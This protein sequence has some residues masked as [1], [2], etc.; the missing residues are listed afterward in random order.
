[1]H[2]LEITDAKFTWG[3]GD[4]K[5]YSNNI[6]LMVNLE[7]TFQTDTLNQVIL[8]ISDM[9]NLYENSPIT[10]HYNAIDITKL[11]CTTNDN[12]HTCNL[13]NLILK[14]T[15]P[16]TE[17]KARVNQQITTKNITLQET[18][19]NPNATFI[20]TNNCYENKCY[21]KS[22]QNF[23]TIKLANSDAGFSRGR[24][25]V[26]VG[27]IRTSVTSCN[28]NECLASIN[29]QCQDG[30][31]IQ[32][33]IDNYAPGIIS[34]DDA[35]RPITSENFQ[36]I[37]DSNPPEIR[38]IWTIQARELGVTDI[39]ETFRV[40]ANITD[41]VSPKIE[42]NIIGTNIGSNNVTGECVL[43]EGL[44]RCSGSIKAQ[45]PER[46]LY[47]VPVIFKDVAGNEIQE[48]MQVELVEVV[49][50]DTPNFWQVGQI[51]QSLTNIEYRNMATGRT[52]FIE[53]PLE[54]NADLLN[55]RMSNFKCTP[56]IENVTG[57]RNQI[58]DARLIKTD[59]DEK[60]A[61]IRVDLKEAGFSTTAENLYTR[62]ENLE[63][64]CGLDLISK[65]DGFFYTTPEQKNFTLK[66]TITEGSNLDRYIFET[67][68]ERTER[69]EKSITTWN[70][71]ET[72]FNQA[73]TICNILVG[74]DTT[75]TGLAVTQQALAA[76]G[77]G[78]ATL[79]ALKATGELL[80]GL[81]I[82]LETAGIVKVCEF[83][84][85]NSTMMDKAYGKFSNS[86]FGEQD[87]LNL[88]PVS[89]KLGIPK[90]KLFDPY[91]SE[92][93]A[94]ISMCIPAIIYHQRIRQ[95]IECTYLECITE[96]VVRYGVSPEQCAYN[97][98]YS[99]CLHTS[100]NI[101]YAMPYTA[102]YSEL[103]S[104]IYDVITD[105]LALIGG[106]T[107]GACALAPAETLS[108]SICV[109]INKAMSLPAH[110][111]RMKGVIESFTKIGDT[112]SAS[113]SNLQLRGYMGRSR[114]NWDNYV[115]TQSFGTT[116]IS[117]ADKLKEQHN[118][119]GTGFVLRCE[120]N[121]CRII[122][123]TTRE[124]VALVRSDDDNNIVYYDG[125]G[126]S[127]ASIQTQDMAQANR[128][129]EQQGIA[130]Y[131]DTQ[132]DLIEHVNVLQGLNSFNI[133]I[134]DV[135]LDNVLIDLTILD[136]NKPADRAALER[137]IR[138]LEMEDIDLEGVV[139]ISDLD[140]LILGHGDDIQGNAA[141]YYDTYLDRLRE[142]SET[143]HEYAVQAAEIRRQ[144]A[145]LTDSYDSYN[146]VTSDLFDEIK[147]M[148]FS[149]RRQPWRE[150]DGDIQKSITTY[151]NSIIDGINDPDDPLQSAAQE[152]LN[153]MGDDDF[154]MSAN[155]IRGELNGVIKDTRGK[156][157]A[158]AGKIARS[159]LM[160]KWS[161]EYDLASDISRIRN[162]IRGMKLIGDLLGIDIML[163]DN[164]FSRFV[165][166]A[167]Q[168]EKLFCDAIYPV[169]RRLPGEGGDGSITTKTATSIRQGAYILARKSPLQTPPDEEPYYDYWIEGGIRPQADG[170]QF[171][172]HIYDTRGTK[173]DITSMFI[174]SGDAV[175]GINT[176]V[177]FGGLG[178]PRHF[179][180]EKEYTKACIYFDTRRL[181]DYFYSVNLRGQELCQTFVGE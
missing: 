11:T 118:I 2:A 28:D 66:I 8:D 19:A 101:F 4:V 60:K 106:A 93:I 148:G 126:Q 83:L 105:P 62:F 109:L 151:L 110:Y 149:D 73:G 171:K 57:L 103:T 140:K 34:R 74:S 135:N 84:A 163:R 58:S 26:R 80:E 9:N 38:Q 180:S 107:L 41:T 150:V 59:L 102:A 176:P 95:D 128:D 169:N 120:G 3:G 170:L 77:V 36:L 33:R 52:I 108:H 143:A 13:N 129:V 154:S 112:T 5:Y 146:S 30:Q 97:R 136:M 174:R 139:T 165:K 86:L 10:E 45:V 125:S 37:C 123:P 172:I 92:V 111:T 69:L 31:E 76:T 1:V 127:W 175:A 119:R 68:Q 6:P 181:S 40:Q 178:T 79:N 117:Q 61:Y 94:G 158:N 131:E 130:N 7:I 16:Q 56:T 35:G 82:G 39:T 67:V 48:I 173:E 166:T 104:D 122:N 72:F 85:C 152:I 113:C 29:I 22:G 116:E 78:I 100:G 25:G 133:E 132:N 90:A 179:K 134:V 50:E 141:S 54:G 157:R 164:G 46:G 81:N 168:P 124:T 63:F 88:E 99:S 144:M 65:K 32:A 14:K 15:N 142:E 42:M 70:N 53:A 55:M 160:A 98:E 18:T 162:G 145:A 43:R 27:Q 20:G 156:L 64:Q 177:R 24:V 44:F 153:A 155:D 49:A 89:Q 159:E 114:T 115:L 147:G 23:I 91:K 87:I 21:I 51:T 138:D 75:Q 12:T 71:V 121:D 137:I 47:D 17:I 96:D 161:L 167:S